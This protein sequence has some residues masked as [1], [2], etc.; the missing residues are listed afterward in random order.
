MSGLYSGGGGHNPDMAVY[1]PDFPPPSTSFNEGKEISS[2]APL[3]FVYES[4]KTTV[5]YM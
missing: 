4:F 2:V 1:D 5:L 3:V